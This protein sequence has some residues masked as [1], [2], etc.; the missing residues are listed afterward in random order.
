M[1]FPGLDL[2]AITEQFDAAAHP[3]VAASQSAGSAADNMDHSPSMLRQAM[4]RLLE[5]LQIIEQQGIEEALSEENLDLSQ[6]G[7]YAIQMLSD[8]SSVADSL[9]LEPESHQLEDLTLQ[10]AIW[11]GFG[12]LLR[13]RRT[14]SW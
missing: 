6:L 4:L 3:V 8:L 1:L 10:M 13:L 14:S 9:S 12:P 11:I 5:L 2:Q 7:D